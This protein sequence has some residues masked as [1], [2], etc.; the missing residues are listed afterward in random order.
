[1]F[2]LLG[3]NMN[4]V[5]YLPL[6]FY[7]T[8][9]KKVKFLKTFLNLDNK[10][11]GL[12]KNNPP[13]IQ[14]SYKIEFILCKNWETSYKKINQNSQ[15]LVVYSVVWGVSPGIV[16]NQRI[17]F[18]VLMLKSS[19]NFLGA[20]MKSQKWGKIETLGSNYTFKYGMVEYYTVCPNKIILKSFK[21]L[22]NN[23]DIHFT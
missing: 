23:L 8:N 17:H 13:V 19:F 18:A 15:L 7:M 21:F 10:F 22:A 2:F 5:S 6:P 12:L 14:F 3:P 20:T 1:M 16:L 11:F 4:G 9:H